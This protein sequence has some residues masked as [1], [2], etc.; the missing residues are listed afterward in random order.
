M[1]TATM[2]SMLQ[3]SGSLIAPGKLVGEL[4]VRSGG[5]SSIVDSDG[6]Q[7]VDS[8]GNELIDY[9]GYVPIECTIS[10]IV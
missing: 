9:P 2:T 3:Y 8:N 1:I 4:S 6:N 7:L 5:V 10:V